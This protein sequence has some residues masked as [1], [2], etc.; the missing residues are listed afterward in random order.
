MTGLGL[1]VCLWKAEHRYACSPRCLL[2]GTGR[3]PSI[4]VCAGLLPSKGE[5]KH[6]RAEVALLWKQDGFN[7]LH[8]T[9]TSRVLGKEPYASGL[10]ASRKPGPALCA[11][12]TLEKGEVMTLA[13]RKRDENWLL[14]VASDSRQL[15]SGLGT[16]S[17]P[18][19]KGM[20]GKIH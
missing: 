18:G 15:S 20:C 1:S 2:W 8:P 14:A 6:G 9:Q 5:Q 16:G 19:D 3:Q 12:L 10:K 7:P 4:H 17:A 11:D 13:R